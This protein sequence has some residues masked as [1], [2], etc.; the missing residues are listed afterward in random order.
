[1][2][3]NTLEAWSVVYRNDKGEEVKFHRNSETRLWT[4]TVAGAP[5]AFLLKGLPTGQGIRHIADYAVQDEDLSLTNARRLL[6]KANDV[7]KSRY[8]Q[9]VLLDA[10]LIAEGHIQPR[11]ERPT[12]CEGCGDKLAAERA[13]IGLCHTC[14][15]GYKE[16]TQ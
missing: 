13:S 10:R 12:F 9:S 11:E 14:S 4:A 2:E 5:D 6:D 1:M 7:F 16:K 8:E 3:P 15:T